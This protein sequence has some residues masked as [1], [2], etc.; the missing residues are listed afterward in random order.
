MMYNLTTIHEFFAQKHIAVAG[1]SRHKNKFGNTLFK[2][3]GEKGY[4]VYPVHPNL[5]SHEGKTCY[6]SV[7]DLPVE[8]TGIVICTRPEH[9]LS[10]A[11]EA[12]TR[13]MRHIWLQ[14]G[15]TDKQTLDL[16]NGSSPEI[17]NGRC[18]LMFLEPVKGIHGFHRWLSRTF[19]VYP[20]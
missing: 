11:K 20:K 12:K 13:G 9:T 15:S 16:L 5:S 6:P 14:Q 8:V 4:A 1:V 3:L 2:A 19:G 10:I 17:I 7:R 18:M